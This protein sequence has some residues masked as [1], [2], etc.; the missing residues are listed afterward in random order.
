MAKKKNQHYVP[1]FYLKR[2]SPDKEKRTIG[3]WNLRRRQKIIGASLRDQCSLD[4]F[5]GKD[6]ILEES[7]E[8]LERLASGLLKRIDKAGALPEPCSNSHAL[9]LIH[10][11]TQW[12]RTKYMADAV[13]DME[14]SFLNY[15]SEL[16]EQEAKRFR[17]DI[18]RHLDNPVHLSIL[19]LMEIFP[20]L[21]DL[22]CKILANQ[23]AIE[24][25]TSDN[26]VVF[27]NQLFSFQKSQSNTGIAVKGLQ[28]FF[29][30]APGKVL[31][32]Y[33]STAYSVGRR[34]QPIVEVSDS[35]DVD[36]INLLQMAN[37]QH[38]VY[39]RDTSID[40]EPLD[41]RG[42]RF[43]RKAMSR[44][45]TFPIGKTENG[46]Q[47]LL[48][49]SMSDVVTNLSLS[50]VRITR[51]TRRWRARFQRLKSRPALVIR[52]QALHDEFKKHQD[53]IRNLEVDSMSLFKHLCAKYHQRK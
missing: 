27:Y 50:F 41:V 19:I 11:A 23:T 9:L 35:H 39:F 5:Y 13:Q 7:F 37:C 48:A 40:L 47:E 17:D 6:L 44:L 30:I 38:N 43:R 29:P 1:E 21:L 18:R 46:S 8:D 2:F 32:F 51:R 34:N 36:Q 42:H 3:I 4:Y 28:I 52:N 14:E 12:A 20:L 49:M 53:K 10:L 24:F 31:L 26:P 15:L 45:E 16:D 25:V 22:D 33:D